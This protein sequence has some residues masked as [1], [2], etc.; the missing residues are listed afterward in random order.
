[1]NEYIAK[2]RW[3]GAV[4]AIGIVAWAGEA[5]AHGSESLG[6]IEKAEVPPDESWFSFLF[7]SAEAAARVTV[8]EQDGYRYIEADGLPDHATGEFPNRGN[9][10]RISE[11]DYAYRVPLYPEKTSRVTP[12]GPQPFGVV[13]NG[14]PM[15]P[16]TA[17][18][19]NNDCSSGWNIEALGGA[20]D[21]GLDRNNAHVQP[22]GA[23]HYHA[24]PTGLLEKFPFTERPI[25][26]GYAADGFPVYGFYGWRD[27]KDSS[28]EMVELKSSYRI[29]QGD[30]QGGPG[31]AYD[32]KYV[33]DYE[34]AAG[35]GDLDACN[36]RAGV[37]SEYPD[38]T[39][40]YVL[41]A[42]YP[43]IPRCFAGT[44]DSSFKHDRGPGGGSGR[45]PGQGSQAGGQPPGGGQPKGGQAGRAPQGGGHPDLNQVAEKLGIDVESLRRALGPPP[46][47]LA[48]AAAELGISKQQLRQALPS[49]R[50]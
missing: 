14:V 44:P 7:S 28:S 38:G 32:G 21:L 39:Y 33:Q 34:Y 31:G 17:E 35:F 9:P 6:V 30:R 24:M 13:L 10:N 3:L 46:P 18:C 37:T 29:R 36:G 23:Y 20:M 19:W 47:D 4:L 42:A 12:I 50:Q 25:L 41:T 15:D 22:G 48:R 2:H 5:W 11:Q 16:G 49:P 26:V 43:F 8:S 40:Y 1:M 45:A 27:P